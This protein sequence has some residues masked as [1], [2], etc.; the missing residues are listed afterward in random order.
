MESYPFWRAHAP[1]MSLSSC[2]HLFDIV[3]LH[4][5]R[6]NAIAAACV[7]AGS[8]GEGNTSVLPTMHIT[9]RQRNCNHQ[10]G[11][12]NGYASMTRA[13]FWGGAPH[14]LVRRVFGWLFVYAPVFANTPDPRTVQTQAPSTSVG[15]TACCTST[16]VL[17]G[18]GSHRLW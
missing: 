12:G 18:T 5:S 14:H 6:K 11:R 3:A 1:N 10:H 8:V 13:R 15:K 4:P 17:F 7:C 16:H 2:G 9:Q